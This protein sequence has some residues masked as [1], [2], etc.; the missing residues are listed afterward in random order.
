MGGI[1]PLSRT[2]MV[3]MTPAIPAALNKEYQRCYFLF[4]SL[5][6]VLGQ[7][8]PSRWPILA[9]NA[10]LFNLSVDYIPDKF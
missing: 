4:F 10:P 1:M 3:F 5:R 7:S 9:F 8:Y 2:S 6:E